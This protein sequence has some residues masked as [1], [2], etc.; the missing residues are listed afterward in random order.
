MNF[1][2]FMFVFSL[3]NDSVGVF[4][5]STQEMWQSHQQGGEAGQQSSASNEPWPVDSTPKEAHKD[6]EDSVSYL[7]M[8]P[9]VWQ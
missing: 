2:K 1:K 9:T 3:T 6:D 8:N 4:V 7:D 5:R